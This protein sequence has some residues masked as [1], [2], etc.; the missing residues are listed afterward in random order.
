MRGHIFKI[1]YHVLQRH[2]D[3]REVVARANSLD[4]F[5]AASAA[6]QAAVR[7][8]TGDLTLNGNA[9]RAAD[10]ISGLV[11]DSTDSVRHHIAAAA[12]HVASTLPYYCAQSYV[13]RLPTAEEM[14]IWASNDQRYTDAH[15]AGDNAAQTGEHASQA[16]DEDAVIEASGAK[17]PHDQALADARKKRKEDKAKLREARAAREKAS[18]TAPRTVCA[19]CPNVAGLKCE[20]GRCRRCCTTSG[21]ACATHKPGGHGAQNEAQGEACCDVPM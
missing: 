14:R 10:D 6:V 20:T 4:D 8:A 12:R 15:A 19:S 18:P 3:L 7:A 16:A 11:A 13:R 2:T 5:S 17:R 21:L 1:F 9:D